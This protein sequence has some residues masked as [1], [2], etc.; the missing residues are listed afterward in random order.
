MSLSVIIKLISKNN[1]REDS[2]VQEAMAKVKESYSW[3][4][5]SSFVCYTSGSKN[6]AV[7]FSFLDS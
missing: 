4:R 1:M 2:E 5:G 3:M 6:G 7:V